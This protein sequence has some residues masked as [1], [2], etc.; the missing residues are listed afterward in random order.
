MIAALAFGVRLLAAAYVA[1]LGAGKLVVPRD[2]GMR[3][4]WLWRGIG[5][6]EIALA[7]VWTLGA[8][9]LAGA[10][11]AVG[12]VVAWTAA[13]LVLNARTG[14]CGCSPLP[15]RRS[16]RALVAR[17]V[18]LGALLVFGALSGPDVNA[19]ASSSPPRAIAAAPVLLLG[20]LAM[21]ALA[22]A[23]AKV[24]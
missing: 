15:T 6:A 3:R 4:S 11:L 1:V 8:E 23:Y 7:V 2:Q 13:G 10:T 24:R 20:V 22:R 14:D 18:L 21:T 9:P 16:A 12:A 19:V 17:N 5:A